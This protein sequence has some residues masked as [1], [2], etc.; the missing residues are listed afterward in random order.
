M[1]D[2]F[3]HLRPRQI[4][5]VS[6]IRRHGQLQ[7]AAE[8]CGLTQPAASR[9]LG[10]IESL[11]GEK[12][13]TRGPKGMEPTPAGLLVARHAR[14]MIND[15]D[16]LSAQFTEL[17]AGRGGTVRIGA[18]TG[19]ALGQIVPA[20]RE[21]KAASPLVEVSV[22]VAPSATLVPALERG[23]LD[24]ALA[25]LPPWMDDRAF[26]I[27]PARDES[28]R[29][30]VR[31]GHPM[32]GA[33]PLG[34]RDLH[35]LPWI[36]QNVGTPIRQAVDRAFHDAGLSSPPNVVTT[37]SLLA[38]V[39]LLRDFDAI[40]P[41]AQEVIDLLLDAP[42]SAGFRQLPIDRAITVEPYMILTLRDRELPRASEKLLAIVRRSI[43]AL[44]PSD[45]P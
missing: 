4:Q 27:E 32:L 36:L 20:I 3:R 9:S 11:L 38:V 40:A 35:H 6:E 1:S 12:L 15:L 17:R 13:F 24:F 25:R 29:L 7:I 28:V 33:G 41:M 8:A 18:V 16:Q 5:L 30:L 31:D 39:A 21:L 2:P 10:E 19:P 44:G 43:R 37:S 42:V 14:R 23:D 22:D 34:V 26:H 45:P